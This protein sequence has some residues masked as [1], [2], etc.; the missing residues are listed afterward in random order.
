MVLF[1]MSRSFADILGFKSWGFEASPAPF[2]PSGRSSQSGNAHL[3][4]SHLHMPIATST[5]CKIRTQHWEADREREREKT[6][7]SFAGHLLQGRETRVP[8]QGPLRNFCVPKHDRYERLCAFFSGKSYGLGGL[9]KRRKMPSSR[10]RYEDIFSQSCNLKEA[11]PVG[12]GVLLSF[13][14]RTC[15][16]EPRHFL[17]MVGLKE[18]IKVVKTTIARRRDSKAEHEFITQNTAGVHREFAQHSKDLWSSKKH[19]LHLPSE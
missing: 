6:S 4:A 3:T 5:L 14:E 2:G 16:L 10:Y 13:S 19:V 12:G 7:P 17:D 18:A 8:R 9:N 1:K 15:L 11:N